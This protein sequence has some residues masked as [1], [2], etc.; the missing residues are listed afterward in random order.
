MSGVEDDFCDIACPP[1]LK[2]LDLIFA[3]QASRF[4]VLEAHMYLLM[5]APMVRGCLFTVVADHPPRAAL[6]PLP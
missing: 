6:T 5:T 3:T 4:V 1:S 2:S